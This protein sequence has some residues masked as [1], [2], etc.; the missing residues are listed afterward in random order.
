M[1]TGLLLSLVIG[2]SV[3]EASR[4]VSTLLVALTSEEC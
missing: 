4:G 1:F 2:G 3:D